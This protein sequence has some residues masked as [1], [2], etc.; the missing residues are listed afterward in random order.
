MFCIITSPK[1][2]LVMKNVGYLSTVTQV[3]AKL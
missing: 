2:Y 1:S 3:Q